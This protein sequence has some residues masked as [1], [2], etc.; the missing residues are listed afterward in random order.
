MGMV[1]EYLEGMT[2]LCNTRSGKFKYS[3]F[4]DF[5]LRNGK[6]FKV[7]KEKI[8]L[9]KI[10]E[11]F[12]NAFYLADNGGKYVYVEGYA[13]TKGNPLPVLHAW[14]INQDSEV[15]DPTWED[16][17][18]YFGTSFDLNYVRKVILKRK[19][20]GVL[21]NYEMRFPLLLGEHTDFKSCILGIE[22]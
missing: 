20:F 6:E 10:R 5:I 3:C 1:K 14:C 21:D 16:G 7:S 9:G 22:K 15:V 2:K 12:R 18:E 8:K 11:C 13:T 19:K 4:E 17:D